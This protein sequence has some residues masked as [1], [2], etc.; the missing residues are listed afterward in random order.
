MAKSGN[1]LF[2]DDEKLNSL[3]VSGKITYIFKRLRNFS[4]V[5][6]VLLLIALVFTITGM[7][8]LYNKA[9]ES[10]RIQGEIR[11]DIQALSKHYLWALSAHEPD[12]KN[13]HLQKAADGITTL[14]DEANALAKV[15]NDSQAI[16]QLKSDLSSMST[17]ADGLTEK[18]KEIPDDSGSMAT[19]KTMEAKN[20]AFDYFND[21]LYPAIDTVATDLKNISSVNTSYWKKYYIVLMIIAII[22]AILSV[23]MVVIMFISMNVGRLKLTDT[24]MKPVNAIRKGSND[25]ANGS[26][27]VNINYSANDELGDLAADL[28]KSTGM[29]SDIVKDIIAT[30]EKFADGDF[31]NGTNHP[32]LYIGD[33]EAVSKSY[34]DIVGKLSTTLNQVCESAGTVSEGANNMSKGANDLAEGSADQAAAVEELTAS[35]DTVTEQT[36]RMAESADKSVSMS[37]NVKSAAENSAFKMGMVTDAMGRI[38]EASKS[39][40]QITNNIE[41]IANQTELLALNASI[42]AARAG[43]A[44]K[45]FAVVA[46]E[47]SKLANQSTE[48]AK[49]THQLIN[50]TLDEIRNGNDVVAETMEALTNMKNSVEEVVSVMAESGNLAKDQAQSMEEI[51]KGIDQIS[52]VVQNN[53][54]TAQESSAVSQE[55]TDQSAELAKLI[56]MFKTQ[57]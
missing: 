13:E 55:L 29:I 57:V 12:V 14:G 49:S 51:D 22:L 5:T 36:R 10:E 39:I 46:E 20:D 37:E 17:V 33:Y 9:Y 18:F 26:L 30:L 24:I 53:S 19:D 44:G 4:V 34:G 21:S 15:Y 25:M 7:R 31:S 40:E 28:A 1:G 43:E 32:E 54:A 47:I 45:G 3:N 48:A 56:G 42:E 50:D 2:N 16:S 35:I 41:A 52:N 38:T 6:V 23:G 11:I 27:N 8:D